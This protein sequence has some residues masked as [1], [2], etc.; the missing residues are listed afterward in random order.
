[1]KQRKQH[2]DPKDS[3]DTYLFSAR[4]AAKKNDTGAVVQELLHAAEELQRWME[5]VEKNYPLV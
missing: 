3:F 2:P 1:M 4:E 5:A